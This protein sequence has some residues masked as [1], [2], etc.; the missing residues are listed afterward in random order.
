V[1]TIEH[2]SFDEIAVS[3]MALSRSKVVLYDVAK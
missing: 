1:N 3:G 2:Q